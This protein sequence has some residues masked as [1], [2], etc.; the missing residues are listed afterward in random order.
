MN[1]SEWE[2][3]SAW[4]GKEKINVLNVYPADPY[5]EK[6]MTEPIEGEDTPAGK[7]LMNI[8]SVHFA[9]FNSKPEKYMYD[10]DGSWKYDIVFFGSSDCNSGY[11]LNEESYAVTNKFAESGRGVLFGH[12]TVCITDPCPFE[13]FS[14]FADDLGI[15]L[16]DSPSSEWKDITNAKVVKKGIITAFPWKVSGDIAIPPC[17]S[18]GQYNVSGTEWMLLDTERWKDSETGGMN[19]FYLVTKNNFG[20]IQTG[21]NT[22]QATDDERKVLANT[23][24]YLY[25]NTGKT[26]MTDNAFLDIDSPEKIHLLD[27]SVSGNTMNI[28]IQAD[29]KGTMYEYYAKALL[30]NN[31][32]KS[33]VEKHTAISGMAG[34]LVK[35]TDSEDSAVDLIEYKDNGLT[36]KDM[37]AADADGKAELSVTVKNSTEPQFIHIFAFDKENNIKEIIAPISANTEDKIKLGDVNFDGKVNAVDAS[38]ILSEYAKTSTNQAAEFNEKQIAAGDID[39][40]KA[41]NAIDASFVLSYYAYTS[42]GG[43]LDDMR[44]W[45]A[46]TAKSDAEKK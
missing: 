24:F 8:D 4:D 21:H 12:D 9:D 1:G 17:H 36:V 33:N 22:G 40:N 35:I 11:D 30:G 43:K 3:Y 37:V 45:M 16:R 10:E 15:V 19:S 29:D 7:G 5:L 14:R 25:Q 27:A 13:I 44:E 38:M 6:W 32:I 18:S 34:F 20:L 39:E 46:L 28:S 31:S 23:L 2:S 41:I 42:T 26:Q